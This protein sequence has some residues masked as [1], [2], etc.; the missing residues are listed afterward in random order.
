VGATFDG[1]FIYMAPYYTG[2]VYTGAT[3]RYDTQGAGF[4]TAAAWSAFDVSTLNA[5]AKG[6]HGAAFDGQY[7]YLA[8][9]VNAA[10]TPHGDVAR[11]NAKTPS[12][13]PLS[14]NASFD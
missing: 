6:Y 8:P 1:R 5:N 12:W 3:V 10:S 14:W 13:L 2:T 7:I 11:F 4:T 9:A